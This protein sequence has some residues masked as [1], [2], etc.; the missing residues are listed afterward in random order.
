MTQALR[1]SLTCL[2]RHHLLRI[3]IAV[4][5]HNPLRSHACPF[6]L[7]LHNVTAFFSMANES[8]MGAPLISLNQEDT[9]DLGITLDHA[10]A[11]EQ[12]KVWSKAASSKAFVRGKRPQSAPMSRKKLSRV[13]SLHD[14]PSGN[15]GEASRSKLWKGKSQGRKSAKTKKKSTRPSTAPL[16]GRSATR[17]NISKQL[18]RKEL[19]RRDMET[20]KMLHEVKEQ[21]ELYNR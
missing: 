15:E 5:E 10:R 8:E 2:V 9:G 18:L 3:K 13:Y 7:D 1:S 6:P 11:E 21:Q 14:L 19:K 20:A 12:E 17:E 4:R 16:R